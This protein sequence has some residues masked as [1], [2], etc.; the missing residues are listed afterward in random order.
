MEWCS[1]IAAVGLIAGS[2]HSEPGFEAFTPGVLVEMDCGIVAGGFMN[3]EGNASGL[4]GYSFEYDAGW[5]RFDVLG[6]V[7][8]GYEEMPLAPMITPGVSVDL[9]D[10]LSVRFGYLP[11]GYR[12][13]PHTVVTIVKW[14]FPK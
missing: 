1:T 8:Y 11:G 14:R 13:M 7:V 4:L 3:S 10:Q 2:W 12:G 6:G 9:T 5:A